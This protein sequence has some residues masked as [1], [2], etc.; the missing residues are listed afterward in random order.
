MSEKKE[1]IKTDF[2]WF[3]NSALVKEKSLVI[4]DISEFSFS[5]VN[6]I[7]GTFNDLV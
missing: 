5:S 1:N 3:S 7:F 6:I 4:D 2:S